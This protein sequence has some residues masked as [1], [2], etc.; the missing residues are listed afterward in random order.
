MAKAGEIDPWSVDIIDVT[1]KFLRKLEE[2]KKMDLRISGRVLLYAAILVRMKS[3][4]ILLEITRNQE[5]K[6]DLEA[7]L[8]KNFLV[9]NDFQTSEFTSSEFLI[10]DV[11]EFARG[12][13]EVRKAVRK[14]VT[15]RDLIEELKKAEEIE[16]RRKKRK[17]VKKETL[18]E[19]LQ[20]PHPE[21]MEETITKVETEINKILSRVGFTTLFSIVN[22]KETDKLV[23]YYVSVL[24]LCFRRKINI[25]QEKIF[26]SDIEISRA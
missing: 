19:P 14:I 21:S 17:K 13:L 9:E 1:D 10:D 16:N 15:L 6:D 22:T 3:E 4:A 20:Y 25:K 23:D 5:V 18:E 26:E 12:V 8:D 24:Y 2:A 11:D 7:E